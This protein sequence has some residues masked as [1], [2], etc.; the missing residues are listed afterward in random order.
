MLSK[1]VSISHV[2]LYVSNARQTALNFCLQYG[3]SPFRYRGLESGDRLRSSHAVINNDVVFVFVSPLIHCEDNHNICTHITRHGDAVKDIAF[4]VNSM[5]DLVQHIKLNSGQEVK[6]WS[7]SDPKGNVKFSRLSA[8]GDTTHT[9]I[10]RNG[11]PKELF[12]PGWQSSTLESALKNSLWSKLEPTNIRF[13]DHLA[14]N[15]PV[16]Q[17]QPLIKW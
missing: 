13:I 4:N 9:L 12:L 14:I 7:E 1:C 16:G 5:D 2:T 10:E 15:Q 8:F 3:F 6:Q 11:Y 17:I